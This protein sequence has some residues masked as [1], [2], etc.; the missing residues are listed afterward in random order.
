MVEA[1]FP[2][3]VLVATRANQQPMPWFEWVQGLGFRVCE[4]QSPKRQESGL[5]QVDEVSRSC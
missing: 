2:T 3:G 5:D 1:G 4:V